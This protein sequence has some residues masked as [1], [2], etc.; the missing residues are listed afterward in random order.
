M[1]ISSTMT[2][3][4]V[5]HWQVRVIK[6][7]PLTENSPQRWHAEIGIIFDNGVHQRMTI[8]GDSLEAMKPLVTFCDATGRVLDEKTQ[9]PAE[10]WVRAQ[11]QDLVAFGNNLPMANPDVDDYEN[12]RF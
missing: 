5:K 3:L 1:I 6:Q 7:I 4:N 2:G 8:C 12:L 9:Q 10:W 11:E